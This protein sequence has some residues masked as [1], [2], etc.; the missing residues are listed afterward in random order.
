MKKLG[1]ANVTQSIDSI[2]DAEFSLVATSWKGTPCLVQVRELSQ[3]QIMA[4]GSFSLIDLGELREGPF[5]WSKW[6]AYAEQNYRLVRAALVSPTYDDIF[7]MVGKGTMISDAKSSFAEIEKLLLDMPR[8]PRRQALE[9]E[10][11]QLR[12]LY[13]LILPDDF[14]A[15]IVAYSIGL[16]KSDIKKVT[17]DMLMTAAVLAERG[18]DNPADHVDG[19]FTSFNRDDINRRAWTVLSEEREAGKRRARHVG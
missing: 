10:L 12:C 7:Q 16:A 13:D 18:H 2:R 14:I 1:I 5:D 11:S 17:R 4:C 9:K 19:M 15:P 6:V 3:V 8:G